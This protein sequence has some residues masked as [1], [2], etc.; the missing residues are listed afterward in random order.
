M[1]N[2]RPVVVRSSAATT[3]FWDDFYYGYGLP[4]P[5]PAALALILLLTLP[6]NLRAQDAKIEF[7]E[8]KVRPLLS[9]RCY[10]CHSAKAK[11]LQA[12]L[13][14]DRAAGAIKGGDSGPAV[15]PG[16]PD[17]SLLIRAVRYEESEMPPDRKLTDAEIAILVKWVSTGA[18]GPMEQPDVALAS[19]ADYDWERFRSK[20]WAFRPVNKPAP[21][22]V[23][24]ASW[25]HRALDHFVLVRLDTAGLRPAQASPPRTLVRRIFFDLVG[26]PPTPDEVE[27][28]VEA[29]KQDHQAAVAGLVDR[30]LEWPHYG[31]R[32]G[33]HWLDVAR[34]SDGYGGFLD[35]AANND[36]WRYRDWVVAAFNSDLP[37][38]R[39]VKLQIAGDLTGNREDV[40]ATGFFAL[41]PTYHSD[42]GDPDSVAQAESETLDDRMDTMSR[43]F[44]ALT[45]ACARCHDHKFDPIPQQDY[46]SFAGIFNNSG[47]HSAPLAPDDVVKAYDDQQVAINERDKQIKDLHTI[48]KKESREL[49]PEEE[50]QL[51]QWNRELA[52][53]RKS[54]PPKY[55]TAH[56]LQDTGSANMKVAIRGNL[57]K[58]GEDAPRRFLRILAGDERTPFTNGSGRVELA[59]AIADPLNPLT[60][61]VM[62]NRIWL[63]HFGKAIVRSP[64]NFGSLGEKPTHPLLLDWL[65]ATFVESGW[66]IKSLHRQIMNSA[67]YQMSS[68]TDE[69]NFAADGDNRLIWR[70]N[71]RRMDVEIWRDSLL[72]VTGELDLAIGGPPHDNLTNTNRR[73]L[74][75][76][77]SRNG[78]VFE[79]DRFLRLFDFPLMRATVAKRPTS[80]VPQQFLFMMNSQFMVARAKALTTRLEKEASTDDER[81]QLAYRL[82]FG[83]LP[84]EDEVRIGRE[85]LAGEPRSADN[86]AGKE[87]LSIFV[88]YAQ[89]LL[90]SNE[91]MY[92]R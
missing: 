2:A 57:R 36:A 31:E 62:V 64:G 17:E 92:V 48:T 42:G 34:Y 19:A 35:N 37:Y 25:P 87:E 43:G 5:R 44:L 14:L 58:P 84:R 91:F 89:T 52:E 40:I 9:K 72:S 76:K 12:G 69:K 26:I 50:T 10:S 3:G 80:I 79:S 70:M 45:V 66:S 29:A 33:R 78:D 88:Q 39:F 71:P 32:W 77:V 82:L 55:A 59:D 1:G 56:A 86:V 6:A 54:A 61:R 53:L 18:V 41:G 21:P 23:S 7:F 15:V 47:V 27:Q 4:M 24:D 8:S 63:H 73:T 11:T 28:F 90:S 51:E 22:D 16:K 46:Y 60:A 38:D 81:I 83:R 68:Q 13:Y 20:H 65:A 30:L 75:A 74:Y 85:F 49:T 67:T